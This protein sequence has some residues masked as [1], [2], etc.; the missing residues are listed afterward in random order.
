MNN[1]YPI[2][3]KKELEMFIKTDRIAC[4]GSDKISFEKKLR[5]PFKNNLANFLKLLRKYEYLC[6]NVTQAKIPFFPEL[7]L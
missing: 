3:N 7:F 4:F 6:I 1:F 2:K 5:N